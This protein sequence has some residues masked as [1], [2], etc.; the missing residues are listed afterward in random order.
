MATR[1]LRRLPIVG[2]LESVGLRIASAEIVALVLW[3]SS[4]GGNGNGRQII[5]NARHAL[6][7]QARGCA[8]D[9]RLRIPTDLPSVSCK[10]PDTHFIDVRC[11]EKRGALVVGSSNPQRR[12]VRLHSAISRCIA[13][14]SNPCF[15]DPCRSPFKA[16]CMAW[17]QT[18]VR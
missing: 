3:R 5:R 8:G 15:L 18:V 1:H 13:M 9:R 11:Q 14:Q 7:H 6:K 12:S 16:H 2:A 10:I 4:V 17:G